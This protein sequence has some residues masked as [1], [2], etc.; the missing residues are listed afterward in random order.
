MFKAVCTAQAMKFSIKNICS[1]CEP[2]RTKLRICSHLR[3]KILMENFLFCAMWLLDKYLLKVNNKDNSKVQ[4]SCCSRF[5][6]DCEH[7]Y[8]VGGIHKAEDYPTSKIVTVKLPCSKLPLTI[9][10]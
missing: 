4:G 3:K 10:E 6:L 1:K 2:I 7:V 8:P 5:I 9:S